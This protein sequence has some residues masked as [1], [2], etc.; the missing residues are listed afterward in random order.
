MDWVSLALLSALLWAVSNL[1]DKFM[2]DK[3]M[4]NPLVPVNL[5]AVVSLIAGT[6]VSLTHGLS[7]LSP[8][9][10]M[11]VM[12]Y[13]IASTVGMVYYFKALSIEEVSRIVPLFN[14]GPLFILILATIFLGEIFSPVKYAGIFLLVAGSVLIAVKKDIKF[15]KAFP[16]M[17][18][19]LVASAIGNVITKYL[20]GF[21]DYWTIFAYLRFAGVIAALPLVYLHHKDLIATTKKYGKRVVVSIFTSEVLAVIALFVFTIA[22]SLG[23]VTLVNSIGALQPLFV[24]MITVLFSMFLPHI[25]KEEID[26][27]T[28][29]MKVI[30][31]ALLIVGSILVS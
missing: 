14:L 24:L 22:V 5:V 12:L 2:L 13:G 25:L 28:I 4:K 10:L 6:A 7:P 30:A 20:L 23:P 27:H 26:R 17:M 9:N 18:G 8:V 21:A 3:W 11:L 31:I 1:I 19:C 29:F 15:G 16:L